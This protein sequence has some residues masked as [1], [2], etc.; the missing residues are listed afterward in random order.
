MAKRLPPDD[1]FWKYV[2]KTDGCWEWTGYLTEKGYG[3]L[4]R[5]NV[6]IYAHRYAYELEV[7]LIPDGLF[8]CHKCDN[9]ACVRPSHM[10]VGTQAD[11]MMDSARKGRHHNQKLTPEIVREIR[12]LYRPFTYGYK[13]IGKRFGLSHAH[14][15]DVVKG[16]IW[17][18]VEEEANLG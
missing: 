1:L 8:L 6:V 14:V 17:A 11:N 3:R 18:H 2:N 12:S 16:R 4:N 7:E 15:R 13:R 9:P 10:F 5:N